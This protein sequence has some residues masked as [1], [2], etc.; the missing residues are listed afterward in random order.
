MRGAFRSAVL[1]SVSLSGVARAEETPSPRPSAA[2]A[3][4]LALVGDLLIATGN[5]CRMRLS[6]VADCSGLLGYYGV[7]AQVR[8]RFLERWSFGVHGAYDQSQ[9]TQ[10]IDSQRRDAE[11]QYRLVRFGADGRFHFDGRAGVDPYVELAA[12]VAKSWSASDGASGFETRPGV[13][14][15]SVGAAFGVAFALGDYLAL[16]TELR[17]VYLPF[18]EATLTEQRLSG[19]AL[20][21]PVFVSSL[22]VTLAAR[23]PL[24]GRGVTRIRGT[25][26]E[27]QEGESRSEPCTVD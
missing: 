7:G 19:S 11:V 23:Y 18:P 14:V 20:E 26:T 2:P 10:G 6:D 9:W 24:R 15:P 22:G 1:V 3:L 8:G 16:G 17:G 4:E 21:G 13:T 27:R 5:F 12:G 25:A